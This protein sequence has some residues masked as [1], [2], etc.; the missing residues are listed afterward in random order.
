MSAPI[1]FSTTLITVKSYIFSS[2]T[3]NK[4]RKQFD[5]IY[6]YV[7]NLFFLASFIH[8]NMHAVSLCSI[9][10]LFKQVLEKSQ[11]S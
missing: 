7:M 10:Y 3:L 9:N 11:L 5:T 8:G 6:K 2:N 1:C 4:Y